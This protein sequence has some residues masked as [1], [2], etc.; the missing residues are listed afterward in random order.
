MDP[1][2]PF[3]DESFRY[4]AECRRLARFARKPVTRDS[5]VTV[6]YL[7]LLAWLSDARAKYAGTSSQPDFFG[8]TA[9]HAHR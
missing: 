7:G 5:T 1:R 3:S 2:D 6:A 8:S 9:G 4:A